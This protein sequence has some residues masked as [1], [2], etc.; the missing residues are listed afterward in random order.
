VLLITHDF[1]VVSPT[2]PTEVVVHAATARVVEQGH[3]QPRCCA[4]RPTT[5]RAPLLAA[6]PSLDPPPRQPLPPENP[7]VEVA[8]L[9]KTYVSSAGWF[10]PKRRVAAARDIA[11]AIRRGETLG[12]VGESGSGKSS[13]ARLLVRLIEPDA[14]AIR[15]AGRDFAACTG[16]ELREARQRI[17]MVF[18]DP[19]ASLNPRRKVG[20]IIADG[21]VAHGVAPR[22]GD[23]ARPRPARAGRPR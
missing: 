18:Q 20:R 7:A 21:P 4:G 17:Q 15:V 16:L 6:V 1:G 9:S 5:T 2:S 12:L 23:G 13:I 10:R 8:G 11:F 3:G 19:F 14:G 22:R